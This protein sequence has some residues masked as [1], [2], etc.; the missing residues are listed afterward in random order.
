MNP[1]QYWSIPVS[2]GRFGCGVVLALVEREGKAD[3]RMFLAGLLDWIGDRP[4][5]STDI[6]NRPIVAERFA[7]IKMIHM[8]GGELIGE[9]SPWWG[10]NRSVPFNDDVPTVGY[11]VFSLLA[12]KQADAQI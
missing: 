6:A 12:E 5:A 10:Y 9:V 2:G 1:G 3:S 4:P 7:H 11:N 8:T